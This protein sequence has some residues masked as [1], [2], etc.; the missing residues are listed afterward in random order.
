[1]DTDSTRPTR[2]RRHRGTVAPSL[3]LLLPV[4]VGFAALTIDVGYMLL[5]RT[6]LQSAA[7]AAA[8]AGVSAYLDDVALAEDQSGLIRLATWR[9][10][11]TSRRNESAGDPT[12]LETMD[13]TLGRHDF[14]NR[15]GPLLS[16]GRWNA[17]QVTVRR[18]RGGSNGPVRLFFA[19]IFGYTDTEL[20]ATAR[21]VVDDR[22]AAYDAEQQAQDG[23]LIPF[24]V[25]EEIYADMV[26]NGPD[27]FSYDGQVRHSGDDIPEIVLYPW[28]WSNEHLDEEG[29]DGA[30]NFGALVIGIDNLGTQPLEEQILNGL[31]SDQLLSTFGTSQLVFKDEDGEELG[32]WVDG[33][34]GMSAGI[35]DAV[36]ARIG[37]VV[38][39][40][41]H[42]TLIDPGSNATYYVTGI[43]YGRIVDVNMTGN[44]DLRSV[45]IQP[46]AY[47]GPSIVVN[48]TA[49]STDGQVIRQMLVQ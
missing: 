28:K 3:A 33:N 32:Y 45:T 48:E 24:T 1:M 11:E 13:V 44:P 29:N 17:V 7:D 14:D 27:N 9:A 2:T 18:T 22:F 25:H 47:T 40:F 49:T 21:A 12:I 43:R 42:R 46:A 39:F 36:E 5:V 20:T 19:G 16:D 23:A 15:T 26:V 38:G 4:L 31:T 10:Q 30:G 6:Q 34:T 41:L 35:K 37:D 8:L